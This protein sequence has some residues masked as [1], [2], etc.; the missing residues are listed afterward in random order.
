[1]KHMILKNQDNDGNESF[2]IPLYMPTNIATPETKRYKGNGQTYIVT[3]KQL[4][5]T[6][7]MLRE[8]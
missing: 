3:K 1:M 4:L 6:R 2:V 7:P 8:T 5:Y